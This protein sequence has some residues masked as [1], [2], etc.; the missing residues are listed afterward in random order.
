MCKDFSFA[1]QMEYRYILDPLK[2]TNEIKKLSTFEI[3]L[4]SLDDISELHIK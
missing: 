3:E 4:G 1:Y 2:P